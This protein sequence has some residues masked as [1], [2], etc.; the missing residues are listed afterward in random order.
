MP[1]ATH[2]PVLETTVTPKLSSSERHRLSARA[3]LWRGRP[4]L[5]AQR[6]AGDDGTWW[7]AGLCHARSGGPLAAENAAVLAS[8]LPVRA[9]ASLLCASLDTLAARAGSEGR[10]HSYM[11]S[12]PW[13]WDIVRTTL[14]RTLWK[15]NSLSTV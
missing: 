7:P 5:D 11:K 2:Q 13:G 3:S 9:I 8:P 15:C 1:S 4:A 10:V 12:S 6:R 14:W